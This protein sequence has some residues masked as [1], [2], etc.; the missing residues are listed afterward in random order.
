MVL[1]YMPPIVNIELEINSP[2]LSEV[3]ETSWGVLPPLLAG[4]L[5]AISGLHT[6]IHDI[7]TYAVMGTT[8]VET[9]C[10]KL[11]TLLYLI[12]T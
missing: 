8:A 5:H 1:L 3:S 9:G 11:S 10:R 12:G 2:K 6:G 4:V 7:C